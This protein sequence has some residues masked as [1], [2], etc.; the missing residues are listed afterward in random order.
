MSRKS[1]LVMPRN[2]RIA[3]SGLN[4]GKGKLT[5]KRGQN[6][7]TVGDEALANEIDTQYG[8]KGTGDVWVERDERV[9]SWL[10]DDKG[11]HRYFF[12][13]PNR[14]FREGWERIFG[15]EIQHEKE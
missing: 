8:L 3:Q 6:S 4:T 1:F 12:G 7:M 5:F 15:K 14:L 13:S 10:R 11:T 2:T 9:S